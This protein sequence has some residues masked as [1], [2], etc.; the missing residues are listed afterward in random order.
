MDTAV[1][2][3]SFSLPKNMQSGTRG[4]L[5]LSDQHLYHYCLFKI[6]VLK[7][8]YFLAYRNVVL[9]SFKSFM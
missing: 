8:N 2:L 6:Q 3:S 5:S 1:T 9:K 4:L 7:R